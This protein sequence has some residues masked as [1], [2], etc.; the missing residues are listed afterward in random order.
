MSTYKF[1]NESLLD[2][3]ETDEVEDVDEDVSIGF[4]LN[5]KDVKR[6]KITDN[7]Y[8]KSFCEHMRFVAELFRDSGY[9]IGLNVNEMKNDVL[10]GEIKIQRN[11]DIY[12]FCNLFVWMFFPK[13]CNCFGINLV[14]ILEVTITGDDYMK[15]MFG[16]DESEKKTLKICK[17]SMFLSFFHELFP[18]ETDDVIIRSF[19]SA[20]KNWKNESGKAIEICFDYEGSDRTYFIY[21]N[22]K[23]L[24]DIHFYS[25]GNF[26]EGFARV[27]KNGEYNF[28]NTSG[29]CI[30][31]DWFDFDGA[32][33]FHEGFARVKKKRKYNF[34]DTSGNYISKKWFVEV[35]DFHEGIAKVK[36]NGK[37]NFI[38]TRGDCISKEWFDKVWSFH[39]GFAVVKKDDEYNFIDTSGNYILTDEFNIVDDFNEGF[40]R[41]MKNGK[42]NFIDTTGNCISKDWFDY[43]YNFQEGFARVKKNGKY[44]FIDTRGN[45]ISNDW[46]DDNENFHEGF[47]SVYENGKYNF[48]D[49]TGNCISKEWFD[50]V[51][52][53]HEGFARVNKDGVWNF[54]D[55]K[56]NFLYKEGM[57]DYIEKFKQGIALVT[58]DG[59]YSYLNTSGELVFDYFDNR[60]S[61]VRVSDDMFRMQYGFG[62]FIDLNGKYV[63]LI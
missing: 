28:I 12:D 46:F 41:V 15:C 13:D 38:D 21:A 26:K 32:Y 16:D 60:F 40:A 6:N 19:V 17:T 27:Y 22:G 45:Y 9:Q 55:K 23:M 29:N 10:K 47:A 39:E 11:L 61:V 50:Y 56:G 43:V 48:I 24:S 34:I 14:I 49:T 33:S 59:K 42:Y 2:G 62:S 36:K 35:G 31:K 1:L 53:F 51:N 3:V 44:N 37:W 7:E 54:I 63:S 8:V 5:I 18:E 58:K 52:N 4:S 20:F 25:V 30:S 57:F